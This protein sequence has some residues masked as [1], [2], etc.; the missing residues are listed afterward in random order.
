MA[1]ATAEAA[2]CT[3]A[4]VM[5]ARAWSALL[6]AWLAFPLL[7]RAEP[8]GLPVVRPLEPGPAAVQG[9]VT[10][11]ARLPDGTL[12][13]GSNVL[14]VREADGWQVLD[15]PGAYAFRALAP[16]ADG[17]L[18]FGAVGGLGY[19]R[20]DDRNQPQV[21]S[22]LAELREAGIAEPGDIW[23]AAALGNGVVFAT[24]DAALRWDGRRW[25]SWSLRSPVRLRAFRDGDAVMLY[26][27]GT[28]LL[29]LRAAGPPELVWAEADLPATPLTWY[30][31]TGDGGVVVGA[32]ESAYRLTAPAG[33][34]P[35]FEL[36]PALS[37][38]L[39]GAVPTAAVATPDGGLVIG[40]LKRGLIC[41]DAT[42]GVRADAESQADRAGENIY[43][44]WSDP[45]GPVLAGTDTGIAQVESTDRVTTLEWKR[46]EVAGEPI[47]I[48]DAG[49]RAA[50]V[51]TRRALYA[52]EPGGLRAL[53]PA[54]AALW[55]GIVAGGEVWLGGFGGLWR[56]D[57]QGVAHEHHVSADVP[58]LLTSRAFPGAVVFIENYSVRA[59]ERAAHGWVP[60]DLGPRLTDTPVSMVEDA[61]GALWVS[62]MGGAIHRFAWEPRD[63]AHPL[64]RSVALYRPGAGLHARAARPQ[65]T[66]L[67][68]EV[69]AFVADG[70]WQLNAARTAFEPM[71]GLE[72]FVGLA[73]APL[74]GGRTAFWLVRPREFG[75]GA[76]P[77]VVRVTA[78]ERGQPAEVTPVVTPGLETAGPV[79][80]FGVVDSGGATLWIGSRHRLLQYR[81][82]RLEPAAPTSAATL[83]AVMVDGTTLP[84]AT[85]RLEFPRGARRIVVTLA[86]RS[87]TGG[88]VWWQTR[89]SDIDAEWN[90]AT[91]EPR[92]EFVGLAPGRYGL[93]AR[94]V[95]RF[96]RPGAVLV[97]EFIIPTPWYRHP[98]A[99]LGFGLLGLGT[100]AA[101]W[102]WRVH[103]LRRQNQRLE[104]L[105]SDRTRELEM[106]NSARSEF[107][108]SIS[109]ELRNPLNGLNGL[110]D[111]LQEDRL[112]VR[113]REIAT[114][115]RAC[116]GQL[117][118]VFEEVLGYAKLESGL[119][120]LSARPFSVRVL[121][122]EIADLFAVSAAAKGG[123]VR[124]V[125]PDGFVDGF[126]ADADRVKT[127]LTNFAGNAVKYAPGTPIVVTAEAI[128]AGSGRVDLHF[129]VTDRGPG[130]PAD[131]QELIFQKFVRGAGARRT[132]V[133]GTGLGLATCRM[134]ARALNGDVGV[135]SEPGRGATFYLR[136]PVS[137]A[138]L[139]PAVV[140]GPDL[141]PDDHGAAALR[142]G[143]ALVVDDE[144]YNRTVMRGIALSLGFEVAEAAT[145]AEA[146]A[147]MAERRFDVV[148]LDWE[149]PDASGGEIAGRLRLG[150]GEPRTWIVA[151]TAHDGEDMP[152]RCA[153][154]G[155]DGY[156]LKPCRREHV[157]RL[158]DRLRAGGTAAFEPGAVPE[159]AA[160]LSFDA[161][162]FYAQG[163]PARAGEAAA[164]F[165][166]AVE[167]EL[168]HIDA[169]LHTGDSG[170]VA[171]AAHR[172]RGLGGIVGAATLV[173]LAAKIEN[174]ARARRLQPAREAR[175]ELAIE[176][177]RLR[178]QIAGA[179]G[180]R[181]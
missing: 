96:G 63:S 166:E 132:G 91:P 180:G 3:G 31:R 49:G 145:G 113:E 122:Q 92:R 97:R 141:A 175:A 148:F 84:P 5:R 4:A 147:R 87:G 177:T 139:P 115:L 62:T 165:L 167:R 109:H 89:L 55:D 154:A 152:A 111:L 16:A 73:A 140:R 29:R 174:E 105:V 27:S 11:V 17:R 181:G 129:E 146:V 74:A 85:G 8:F 7:T 173:R 57:A 163:A 61:A 47:R 23:L 81:V 38:A 103:R 138:E 76:A 34:P 108:E 171:A 58:G 137:R 13:A 144:D 39:R 60:R 19:V 50:R 42:R 142:A 101:S 120:R 160:G 6:A 51:V 18:W 69:V 157:S 168:A 72:R 110:L 159:P 93:A 99:L 64:L 1:L 95:D 26:R 59:L 125:L 2:E 170:T 53:M 107:L 136:V 119:I 130:I 121:L 169:A 162:Q 25:E 82:E 116:A 66:V 71:T 41:V 37:D 28:G 100:V 12:W 123:S 68:N 22:L 52:A 90:P 43:S 35:A 20:R 54:E 104:H 164:L 153:A 151:T 65:L 149:L 178:P 33:S 86:P 36:M 70:V 106:V 155:M 134:L 83:R 44:L 48:L 118:R 78:P 77:V 135:E 94:A 56:V 46:G 114:S 158:L 124:V 75:P 133:S 10:A 150:A 88:E 15:V 126:V 179:T 24:S 79:S 14:A 21:V 176:W 45:A 32:G 161:F 30:V 112:G 67:G 127:V 156:L 80:A 102:R 40:T 143:A 117:T 131:E 9:P 172:L 98:L 128:P